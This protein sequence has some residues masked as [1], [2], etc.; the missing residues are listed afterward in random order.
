MSAL[1]GNRHVTSADA[2]RRPRA[3]AEIQLNT[4]L[5]LDQ[6][7]SSEDEL[8]EA[9]RIPADDART[10]LGVSISQQQ[11]R[12]NSPTT[13]AVEKAAALA[14]AGGYFSS[15]F[16]GT[17]DSVIGD[18]VAKDEG[19]EATE[20]GQSV[21]TNGVERGHVQPVQQG[22]GDSPERSPRSP[23][24]LPS[25]WRASSNTRK[26][27]SLLRDG[28][29]HRTQP[30]TGPDSIFD[31]WQRA[32]L[33]NLPSMPK[34]FSISSPFSTSQNHA[35][36]AGLDTPLRS[37]RSSLQHAASTGSKDQPTRN[38]RQRSESDSV[39]LSPARIAPP[40]GSDR[41][42]IALDDSWFPS[43][44]L[45]VRARPSHRTRSAS[46]NSLLTQRTMSG[47]SSL[48]DD[49]RFHDV[50]DQVNSRFKAFKDTWQDSNHI[51]LPSLPSLTSFK[52]DFI[53]ERSA[54]N[55]K[56]VG[57]DDGMFSPSERPT[58][59]M[60]R[61]PYDSV[62]AAAADTASNKT[63]SQARLGDALKR[64]E[65]DIVILGGYRGSILR[66]AEPPHR[67]VWVPV[68][69]GLNL[70]KVDLEVDIGA[71]AD[72][73]PSSKIIPGGMLTH[74][75]PVDVARRLFKR[76][77]AC[78]KVHQGRLRVHDY[79]Y[80]WRLNPLLLS[81]QLVSFLEGLPCNQP[82]VPEEQRGATVIAHSLGGLITR[83]AVNK[84]PELFRGVIYAGVPHTCVNILG[85]M[86]NGDEVLLS[87][88]VLTAQVNFTI[89]T[90]FALLPLDGRCFFDKYTKDEYPVDF[91]DP[92]T[93]IEHRLSPCVGR[94]LPPLSPPEKTSGISGYVNSVTSALPSLSLPS[95]K[96]SVR[97]S[98]NPTDTSK[99]PT[100]GGAIGEPDTSSTG[101]VPSLTNVDAN[102]SEK[103]RAS[104]SDAAT[105]AR[106][107]VTIPYDKAVAYL[108]RT[109]ALVK[110]F[111]QELTFDPSHAAGNKY[112]PVAVIYGKSIPT[113]Y[114]ARVNGREGIRHADAYDALAFASGDGV[115]LARAAMVPEGYT[116]ARGGIVSSERGH[117]TLLGDLEAVG[118]CLS[119]VI[120]ARNGGVGC[121]RS[122]RDKPD[123]AA[124]ARGDAAGYNPIS[125]VLAS[126]ST[127]SPAMA[128]PKLRTPTLAFAALSIG[129]NLAIIGCAAHTLSVFNAEQ[130]SNVWLLPL[131]PNHFDTRELHALL[132]TATVIVVLNVVLILPLF[133]R[134]V[135]LHAV[136]GSAA[137]EKETDAHLWGGKKLPAPNFI[138]LA[139]ALLS[140]VCSLVAVVFPALLN[141]HAPRR[142][143]LQTWTWT[144]SSTAFDSG[145]GRAGSGPSGF[146]TLC[147]E[148]VRDVPSSSSR[149]S[150]K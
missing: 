145:A 85:P 23:V 51:K 115:V 83:H 63:S 101:S 62:K 104:S 135:S 113:V 6:G 24:R 136:I 82:G 118:R 59:P 84:R 117:V 121:G 55:S 73:R 19:R 44:R 58:D 93:W 126:H 39:A 131:W 2:E 27:R 20:A 97:R 141:T 80:D 16:D 91:F 47:V 96:N 140:T 14:A 86:R 37:K 12:L 15:G 105:S 74:I 10:A 28:L 102:Y 69:V 22:T 123:V 70:R 77:R 7:T 25:P 36:T 65:G 34:H 1:S 106:T 38:M 139:S 110:Q 148:T 64:L 53:R 125:L 81:K 111:K 50:R 127:A 68:K 41:A 31:G 26:T 100:A 60:T 21:T 119:S 30:S 137:C 11:T 147:H 66:S 46:E 90:S 42:H 94:P 9:Q 116:T 57:E 54:S 124:S 43:E 98:S 122:A 143:T 103:G 52:P 5:G 142:D 32:F 138:A 8:P 128:A 79:G 149:S 61:Q 95:R 132:G 120:E 146:S 49:R 89:R 4:I 40:N 13:P 107:A 71:E 48:G 33:S 133:V 112:P 109:L 150:V 45:N 76:V 56:A 87:S 92:Q 78:E 18:S 144:W 114:G 35:R 67:Q 3:L 129:L 134:A 99:A 72:E 17:E 130:S 75:G 29:F 108:T 88:R